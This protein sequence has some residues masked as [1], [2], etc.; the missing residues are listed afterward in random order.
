MKKHP[1]KPRL[2]YEASVAGLHAAQ[3]AGASVGRLGR[4]NR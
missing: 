4:G 1:F 2:E 3:A